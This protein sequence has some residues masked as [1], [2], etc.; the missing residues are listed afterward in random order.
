MA[1]RGIDL[2]RGFVCA[3]TQKLA[4]NS[5]YEV[6]QSDLLSPPL[7]ALVLFSE[8]ETGSVCEERDLH[9]VVSATV[10]IGSGNLT[11]LKW[12]YTLWKWIYFR[13]NS[14]GSCNCQVCV[15]FSQ[16]L[17]DI[18]S[19]LRREIQVWAAL[20]QVCNYGL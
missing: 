8:V 20:C 13:F 17:F 7:L 4:L 18:C 2:F 15:R 3:T 14:L 9:L 12:F 16:G 10:R 19:P 1:P 11:L 5:A 6:A